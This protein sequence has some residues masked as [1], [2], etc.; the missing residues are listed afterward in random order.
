MDKSEKNTG[1][2]KKR[3]TEL[4]RLEN[5]CRKAERAVEESA[6][7]L[8][9]VIEKIDEGITFS[10]K[11]GHFDVFN[12]KMTELTGYAID[13]ANRHK[14]FIELLYPDPKERDKAMDGLDEALKKGKLEGI[15]TQIRAKDGSKK[16]LFV[17]TVVVK[18]KNEDMLLSVYRDIT[19]EK[20]LENMKED[21]LSAISHEV[22]TPL[23]IIKEGI[24]L[25]LDQ[26]PGKI[27]TDQAKI[28]ATA[29]SNVD[30]LT[31]AINELLN[32]K[33]GGYGR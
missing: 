9:I 30:R 29:K 4:E 31:R 10:N 33:G 26:I 24:S 12:S 28:L 8:S 32:Y 16:T 22:R 15:E 3:L 23:S 17:S 18:W 1:A 14:N 21:I 5:A 11:K 20:E 6:M 19:R 13:D 7:R 2:L 25:V 27:N